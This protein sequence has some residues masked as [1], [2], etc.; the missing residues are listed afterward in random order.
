MMASSYAV[1]PCVRV[2]PGAVREGC[3]GQR[4]GVRYERGLVID[5]DDRVFPLFRTLMEIAVE[6]EGL[7]F[8]VTG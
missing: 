6:E 2:L 3:H 7:R 5:V 1:R 4:A 8:L